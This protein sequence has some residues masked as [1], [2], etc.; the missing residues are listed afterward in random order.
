[1]RMLLSRWIHV[2]LNYLLVNRAAF[3]AIGHNRTDDIWQLIKVRAT[4]MPIHVPRLPDSSRMHM[5]DLCR[6]SRS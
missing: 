1:M 2:V 4:T 5:Y 3:Y 6:A